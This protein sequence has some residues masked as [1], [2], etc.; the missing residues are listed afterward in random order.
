MSE[1]LVLVLNCGSSSI[2]FAVINPQTAEEKLQG[3]AERLFSPEAQ[4]VIKQNGEKTVQPIADADHAL[5]ISLIVMEIHRQPEIAAALTAVGHRVV[6]GGEEFSDSILLDK[7]VLA[8]IRHCNHLAPLHNPANV[9]GIET[10]L[11]AFPQLPQIAVF[12]TAFHQS[13]PEQ[14]YIYPLPYELY[15]RYGVRRYG[16]HGTSFRYV[17]RQACQLLQ[18]PVEQSNLIIAHL[19]NG[20]SVSA[21]KN[22]KS[23]DTSMGMTP[24][25]GVV[26][27]TRSG[28]IDPN[29]HQYLAQR[30]DMTLSEIDDLLLKKSGL[31]GISGLSNDCRKIEQAAAEGH[32]RAQLSLEIY[33]YRLAK[34]IASLMV[35]LGALDALVFTGGIGENSSLIRRSVIEQ[36]GFLGLSID[37]EANED[38]VRGASGLITDPQ[39]VAAL[40]VPTNE[41][42]MIAQDAAALSG[43]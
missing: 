43:N 38:K 35:P 11:A 30:V 33:C 20:A 13:I 22:G 23:M 24:N 4:L 27:G 1:T 26:H 8:R 10:A 18:R 39:G 7:D 12:D 25:E 19:G 17:A 36:L 34:E 2:K 21:V 16:F 42:L 5:A 15:Q 28:S 3:I 29:I 40:V 6:H 41:E 9:S 32:Q 37:E 31:L 14:A